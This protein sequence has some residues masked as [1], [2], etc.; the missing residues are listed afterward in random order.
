MSKL[1][2]F[3]TQINKLSFKKSI[4]DDL[5]YFYLLLAKE[6]NKYNID[7]INDYFDTNYSIISDPNTGGILAISGL[8]IKDNTFSDV[9]SN[10]MFNSYLIY[11]HKGLVNS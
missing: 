10:I 5:F 4:I 6:N 1:N 3:I 8:K 11:L 2:H 7:E 9:S